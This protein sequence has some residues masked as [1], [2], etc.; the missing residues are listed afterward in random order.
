MCYFEWVL[1][2]SC[3]WVMGRWGWVGGAGGVG[4]VGGGGGCGGRWRG[5]EG[6]AKSKEKGLVTVRETSH[7]ALEITTSMSAG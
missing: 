2:W 5:R 3:A 1:G 7:C 6:W 4:C